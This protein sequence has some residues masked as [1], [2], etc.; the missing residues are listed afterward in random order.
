MARFDVII[1]IQ[2]DPTGASLPND[3]F[4]RR[5]AEVSFKHIKG[6]AYRIPARLL[7]WLEKHPDVAYVSPDRRTKAAW[8]DQIPAV[9]DD[10]ALQQYGLD[11]SGVGIA[12][13]DSG[14]YHH[15]I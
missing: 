12:V 7:A 1:P 13:I 5:P 14:V 10:L 11:G 15:T 6:A 4:P 3:G 8:D 2:P 9:M